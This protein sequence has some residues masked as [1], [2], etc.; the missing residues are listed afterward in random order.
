MLTENVVVQSQCRCLMIMSRIL[1]NASM[2]IE[3]HLPFITIFPFSSP[4][5]SAMSDQVP[6]RETGA[7]SPLHGKKIILGVS[8]GIAAYKTPELVRRLRERG[9]DVRVVM[10]EGA[11]AFIT[12]L[13]LQAVSDYLVLDNVLDPAAEAAMGHIKLGKWADL[14]ILA[15]ATADLIARV[16]AGMA[17]DMVTTLILATAAPV[18][19]VP[20]MNQQMYHNLATQH[21][22]SVLASRGLMVWGP[23]CG[24]QACGDVGA[25]RMLDP[26]TIVDMAIDHLNGEADLKH[27]N[28]MITAGPTQERIDPVRYITNESSGKMGYSIAAAAAARGANVTLISG[29]VSLPTPANVRRVNVTT[30]LDMEAAVLKDVEGQH[31][32]IGCAAVADYRPAVVAEEKIKK[33]GEE[34][35]LTLVKNPD[36]VAEVGALTSNRP[37]VVGFAAETNN[38]ESNAQSKLYSKNLDL[39]CA[40]DVSK[41]GQGF[42]S[43]TNALHLFWQGGD[44]ILP[45]AR[46]EEL[47]RS[48]L[49]EIITHYDAKKPHQA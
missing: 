18:A 6:I 27:L 5:S 39:I 16:A 48:L 31:I 14:V 33:K 11:K 29:P 37:F 44:K 30:A 49:V 3:D 19:V 15:P 28:I 12:P 43:D 26:L 1:S 22:L 34:I 40:N 4:P 36:I 2:R 47:A 9:A 45:M 35:T 46:K 20:A 24:S 38:V 21:N 41:D 32:F 8:G 17:D 25:G 10:T 23:A 13:S 7:P 42:N